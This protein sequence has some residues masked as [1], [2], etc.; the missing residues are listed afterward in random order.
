V[1]AVSVP[2]LLNWGKGRA[3]VGRH[4]HWGDPGP[5]VHCGGSTPIRDCDGNHSHKVCA[6]LVSDTR[7]T[8]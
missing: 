4:A 5:C 8:V 6:E 7:R 3:C 2:P 1:P